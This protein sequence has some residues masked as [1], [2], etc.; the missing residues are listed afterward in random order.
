MPQAVSF[1]VGD[2][3]YVGKA[4]ASFT[5]SMILERSRC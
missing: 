3:P 1:A 4:N 2:L 5:N